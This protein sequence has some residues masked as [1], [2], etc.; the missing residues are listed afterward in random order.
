MNPANYGEHSFY[1]IWSTS[2]T[3]LV[4]L[5]FLGKCVKLIWKS[6]H[7]LL[8]LC[9]VGVHMPVQPAQVL[10]TISFPFLDIEGRKASFSG[11]FL[12]TRDGGDERA[13]NLESDGF[14]FEFQLYHFVTSWLWSSHLI[15]ELCLSNEMVRIPSCFQNL[16]KKMFT[17]L[18]W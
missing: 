17:N 15:L 2:P 5:C 6:W 1:F 18:S 11:S 4:I 9:C 12:L 13:L 7:C 3:I 16:W 10:L 8:H 14:W